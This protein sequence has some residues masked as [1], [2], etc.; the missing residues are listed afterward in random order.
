MIDGVRMELSI[1][2]ADNGVAI[3]NGDDGSEGSVGA[4]VGMVVGMVVGAGNPLLL[5]P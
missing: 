1:A 5:V 2:V 4:A 3:G